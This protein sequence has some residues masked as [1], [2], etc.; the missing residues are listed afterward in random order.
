MLLFDTNIVSYLMRNDPIGERYFQHY[1]KLSTAISFMTVAELYEG[2][3]RANWGQK[4][5]QSLEDAIGDYIVYPSSPDIVRLWAEI[6]TA[7]RHQPIS[8]Q[9]AWIAA[10]ALAHFCP[11]VTHDAVDFQGISGLKIIS[12]P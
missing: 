10:T 11:L 1:K 4:R 9:D 3:F 5:M 8:A 2:A 7:R 12:A 6:R